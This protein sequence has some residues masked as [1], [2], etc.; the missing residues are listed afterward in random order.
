MEIIDKLQKQN[1]A[2]SDYEYRMF[3]PIKAGNYKLSI[4]GSTTHYCTPRQTCTP[5]MYSTMELAIFNRN[6]W[7]KIT[8][9]KI[10]K[11]FTRY[12][13]LK[14]RADSLDS[15]YCV[16]GYVP[17]DLINDLYNYLNDLA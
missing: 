1:D 15:N 12:N 8:K 14:E 3:N 7:F 13:E 11:S 6:G 10:I 16:F 9:S 4:Q 17:I 5:N 2:N